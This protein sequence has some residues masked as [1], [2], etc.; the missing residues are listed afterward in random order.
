MGD[1]KKEV[2]D[3]GEEKWE[4]WK[5][6]RTFVR[7]VKGVYGEVYK[8]L[9]GK[10][11][12]Y[13]SKDWKW[14][15]GPRFYHRAVINPE[16]VEITQM[17]EG[18]V[19]VIAPGCAG[20][21]HGHMNSAVFFILEGKGYDIHDG[22]RYDWEKGDVCIVDNA[23]V[24]QH[25]NSDPEKPVKVVVFKAKPLFLFAHMIFQKVVEYPSK[26]PV[27]GFPDYYPED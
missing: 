1:G 18:H 2:H 26:D 10:P 15:G 22:V 9:L 4:Q 17:I 6:D 13:K 27:P 20:Q 3:H 25:L 5:K 11:R 14:K 19:D 24:H 23:S 12:V 16:S 8:E 21:K 7:A